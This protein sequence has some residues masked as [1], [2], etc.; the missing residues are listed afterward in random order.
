MRQDFTFQSS[1]QD[2]LWTY[3]FTSVDDSGS[4]CFR[5]PD[6]DIVSVHWEGRMWPTEE[7]PGPEEIWFTQLQGK[8][9]VLVYLG[10]CWQLLEGLDVYCIPHWNRDDSS[11]RLGREP[12]LVDWEY[13]ITT[14]DK[15]ATQINDRG[16]VQPRLCLPI[17]P[18]PTQWQLDH[19]YQ[20]GLFK[21]ASLRELIMTQEEIL[22]DNAAELNLFGIKPGREQALIASLTTREKP[23]LTSIL[24]PREIFVG[25]AVANDFEADFF[26]IRSHDNLEPTLNRLISHFKAVILEYEQKIAKITEPAEALF[27]MYL[28]AEGKS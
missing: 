13:R 6:T 2:G 22:H 20:A 28:L 24:E 7:P 27:Q 12:I 8:E 17:K 19:Q 23:L 26:V 10:L 16:F 5:V 4:C 21:M 15:F 1:H 18:A 3:E 11:T 14:E 9:R 25:L